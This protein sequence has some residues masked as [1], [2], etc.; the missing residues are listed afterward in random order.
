[1]PGLAITDHG[2]IYGVKEF[3]K[4]AKGYPN[5]KPIIGCEIY[6]TTFDHTLRGKEYNKYNHLILLAK[7][8]NGYKNLLKIVSTGHVEGTYYGKPRIHKEILKKYA[9]D[10][11]CCS[12]CIAGEVQRAVI[13][14]NMEEAERVASWYK[15]IFGEDYYLEVQLHKSEVQGLPAESANKMVNLYNMQ[16]KSNAGLFEIGKKLGIK[17]IATNDI[18]FVMKE[19]GPA[20]DRLICLTTNAYVDDEK[21]MRYSQQEYMKSEEEMLKIFPEHPEVISNTL[22]ICDKIESYKIDKDPILP[23]FTISPDFITDIDTHLEKYKGV[24]DAGRCDAKGNDRGVKFTHSVAFLCHLT[25]EGAHKRY[26]ETLNKEQADRIDF[27]LKTISKMGFPDYFLIVQDFIAAARAQGVAVGPGRGSAAGSVVAYCLKITN[28]DPIRYSLLFE[29]FLNPDRIS[30]PDIDID[31]DDDGRYKALKYIETSYGLDHISHVITFGTMAAKSSIKD[32]ARISRLPLDESIRL[33]KLVADK[34]FEIPIEVEKQIP[35]DEVV[36]PKEKIFMKD[37]CVDDMDNPGSTKMVPT[38]FKKVKEI[39]KYKP[40]LENCIKFV[41]ELK[42]EFE[43]GSDQ[44]KEVLKY[45]LQLEGSIRQTGVHACAMIIGRGNLIDYI[46]ITTAPDKATGEDV[47][48]SQFEGKYIEDVGMLKMDFL[49]LRTLSIIKECVETI[50]KR[51]GVSID[52]ESIP[53]DDELTYKLYS[54]GDTTSVF[55]FESTGMKEWLTK[56]QPNRFEDL[57]AMNALYRPGPMDYIPS[58]VERKQGREPIVYDLAEMDEILN[59]TYG[60]TVYQEQVMLLSQKLSNFTKGQ[61]DTLRKA[62]GK[63]MLTVLE[64]LYGI[65]VEGGMANGHPKEI[66]DKIWGDWRKFAEYAFNKSHSTCYAWVSYQTGYLKAHYPAEFQAANLSKNISNMDEIKKIMADCKKSGIK[67]LNPDINESDNKFTVNKEGNI[68]FGLGGIKG[69]GGNI[70]QAI[71]KERDENGLFTDIFDFAER[72]A[73]IVNRKAFESLIYS[74]GFDSLGFSRG[75]FFYIP[76]SGEA[77]I[78]ALVRYIEL[79]RKD[80]S[81]NAASLFGEAEEIMPVK[82]EIPPKP[83]IENELEILEREKELVGM[84][85]SSHPLDKYSFELNHLATNSIGELGDLI[86]ECQNAKKPTKVLL[87]G[88]IS[89]VNIQTSKAGKPWSKTTVEDFNGSYEF[90]LYGKDHENFL[91]YLQKHQTIFIEGNITER[92]FI[93]PEERKLKGDPPYTFKINKIRLLG[94]V[95]EDYVSDVII[96]LDTQ[97]INKEFRTKL[98]EILNKN[99]GNIPLNVRLIDRETKYVIV[100]KS[101]TFHLNLNSD[102]FNDLTALGVDYSITKK[103]PKN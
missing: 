66:L 99:K 88:L 75:Q 34:P 56:L 46:P 23:V 62:M 11:V 94:N 51:H 70:V 32:V 10:L 48:V 22:E 65:F 38:R 69:F 1:M 89:A 50:H 55:Q 44:V 18:H 20:H 37:I 2:N 25:Y 33:T 9:Q 35:D 24:I 87:A 73:G 79:H 84:Y 98:L 3:L 90:N 29:R 54:R 78:D 47:W 81:N 31:F 13:A 67:I 49:G 39:K 80:S 26:G 16:S 63:K 4:I 7:N 53:I 36:D 40:T 83:E 72:M 45:A 42:E 41:P 91:Q 64:S 57:I 19:D 8:E 61:A 6:T 27:E 93:K 97:H 43:N 86:T 103:I 82:P 28:L 68:R 5:V 102:L 96:N 59:D 12:A 21:R 76:S 101:R 52:I 100:F 92:Y 60:I 30:M 77:F 17:I 74:G 15:D 85:L 58:F 14:D 71:L 95:A